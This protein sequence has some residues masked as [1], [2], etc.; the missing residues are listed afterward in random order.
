MKPAKALMLVLLGIFT[1]ADKHPRVYAAQ[2]S[3]YARRQSCLEG[4]EGSCYES[5]N[6][7][8][9]CQERR[10][11]C[12][13]RCIEG[14]GGGERLPIALKIRCGAIPAIGTR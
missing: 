6:P 2:G 4:C 9:Y 1:V 7:D 3:E 10:A 5:H 14:K 13:L 12:E 11:V 8:L